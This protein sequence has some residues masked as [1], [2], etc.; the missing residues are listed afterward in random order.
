MSVQKRK[1]S[2]SSNQN[3]ASDSDTEL[4]YLERYAPSVPPL[5]AGSFHNWGLQAVADYF[6]GMHYL[7]I[8]TS[9]VAHTFIPIIKLS[10]ETREEVDIAYSKILSLNETIR[11]YDSPRK[12]WRKFYG[13]IVREIEWACFELRK[14]FTKRAYEEMVINIMADYIEE[15][16]GSTVAFLSKMVCLG[17][18]NGDKI[19]NLVSKIL[20]KMICVFFEDIVNVSGF[21]AGDVEVTEFDLKEGV[22]V[23]EVIDC[24]MLHA[25][26]MKELPEESCLLVCKGG[27][28]KVFEKHRARMLFDPR[29]P[30]TT[31]EIRFF[32]KDE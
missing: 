28:E 2:Q 20:S 19:P 27:C 22:M 29:L 1:D 4:R 31:C 14:Y 24:L 25:P 17:K 13:N 10:A 3:A 30:E 6:I 9:V 32:I 12:K 26:G 8:M 5:E 11:F 18:D 7:K 21:L 23:L 15:S 16:M